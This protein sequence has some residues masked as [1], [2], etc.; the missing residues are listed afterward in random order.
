M[1]MKASRLLVSLAV[2]ATA[3]GPFSNEGPDLKGLVAG[4]K[5]SECVDDI[6]RFYQQG[7]YAP[8][9][10]HDGMPT[11]QATAL[12]EAVKEASMKGLNPG[13][14]DSEELEELSQLQPSAPPSDVARFDLALTVSVMQYVSDLRKGRPGSKLFHAGSGPAQEFDVPDFV[15]TQLVD[16]SDVQ[17]ALAGLDPSFPDYQRAEGALQRYLKLAGP[18]NALRVRRLQL[19]LER[20]RWLPRSVHGPLIVVNIPEF[21]LRAFDD[22]DR[23]ALQ[24]KVVV[25]KAYGHQTPA[26][27]SDLKFVIFRPYWDVPPS[28][29]NAEILPK[30]A[31]NPGYLARNGF[32]MVSSQGGGIRIRQLP[33]N[34]N[35]LGLVK[36][37]FPNSYDVYMHGTP[38]TRLFLRL[39]RDFSHGCIR[40]ENPA[41]LAEW[42]LRENGGWTPERVAAAM[43]GNKTTTVPLNRQIPVWIVY[44][45][46][47]ATEDGEVRFLDDIYGQD[48]ALESLLTSGGRGQCPRE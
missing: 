22:S 47:I 41:K 31:N 3:S 15:R 19:T 13:D 38:A 29:Q 45:T 44:I 25:G 10:T 8:A 16:A 36:F 24:M 17:S 27:T 14:Y 28:I 9:W 18:A 23:T 43:S 48:A 37:L 40:L 46:A 20:Y 1:G 6:R 7:A 12:L 11:P 33:G 35:A 26:F 4:L 30:L 42:V 39:R 5:S 2:V 21:R 32:E 34:R